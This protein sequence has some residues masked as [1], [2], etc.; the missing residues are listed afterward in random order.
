MYAQKRQKALSEPKYIIWK[1]EISFEIYLKY[2]IPVATKT[3][4]ISVARSS[5]QTVPRATPYNSSN[6]FTESFDPPQ[7]FA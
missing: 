6:V 3:T 7:A 1:S 2:N 4:Q 5:M